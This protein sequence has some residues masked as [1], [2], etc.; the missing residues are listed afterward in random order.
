MIAWPTLRTLILPILLAMTGLV[1][2]CG[3]GGGAPGNA[4]G[5]R[6][7]GTVKLNDQTVMYG[8][9][10]FHIGDR[11]VKSP[12]YP[13]GTYSLHNPPVGAAKVVILVDS[14]PPR[15]AAAA[16]AQT[17]KPPEFVAVKVP[18]KY[19][20]PE[21]TDLQFTIGSGMQVFDIQLKGE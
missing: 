19:A 21:T 5:N 18:V 16:G 14:Q 15:M 8:V 20:K 3:S 6:V 4:S 11:I 9:V 1:A 12:I 7:S 2:G 17:E 13:D 10:A